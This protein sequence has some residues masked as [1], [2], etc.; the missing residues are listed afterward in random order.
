[1]MSKVGDQ[2]GRFNFYLERVDRR[3]FR[4]PPSPSLVSQEFLER[5]IDMKKATPITLEQLGEI[6]WLERRLNDLLAEASSPA[7][8]REVLAGV[9]AD[10]VAAHFINPGPDDDVEQFL[11]HF[12]NTVRRLLPAKVKCVTDS[13]LAEAASE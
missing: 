8:G 5:T 4:W 10:S 7:L 13:V 11:K 12:C 3:D 9:Y 2:L 1:M 6:A